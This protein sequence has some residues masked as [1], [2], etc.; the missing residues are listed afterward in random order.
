[1]GTGGFTLRIGIIG[2]G[3]MGS[4]L[5]RCLHGKGVELVVYNRTRGKAEKLCSEIGCRVVD[6]PSLMRDVDAVIVFVF[7]DQAVQGVLVGGDGL[8]H[9]GSSTMVLNASTITPI[10][11]LEVGEALESSGYTYFEAPVYGSTDEARECRL[12]SMLGGEQDRVDEAA[13]I[14]SLYSTETIYVGG[15]SKAMALKLALNNI[16]LSL[17]P[18]IGE[19]LEL[20]EAYNVSLEKF[21]EVSMKLWF[22]SILERYMKRIMG[23]SGNIRFTV[24]GAAKDYRTITRALTDKYYPAIISSAL[25]NYYTIASG[26]MGSSDYPKAGRVFLKKTS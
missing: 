5:A 1:M 10:T 20:L 8:I 6:K 2:T 13:R 25:M 14:T 17:P 4:N 18:I 9:S 23:G 3:L 7:D 19:S 26:S 24:K 22:G 11:S 21:M 15:V 16:G 12:V